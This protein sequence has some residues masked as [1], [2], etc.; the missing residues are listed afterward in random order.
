MFDA[1][2]I[3][4]LKGTPFLTVVSRSAGKFAHIPSYNY[5]VRKVVQHTANKDS[6]YDLLA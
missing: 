1:S 2:A 6:L 3:V 4:L 5:L